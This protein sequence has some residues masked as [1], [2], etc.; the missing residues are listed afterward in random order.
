MLRTVLGL[1]AA[2]MFAVPAVD[3]YLGGVT[4]R[5][6]LFGAAALTTLIVTILRYGRNRRKV[7]SHD[8][9]G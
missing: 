1:I 2:A 7:R 5:T 8:V 4:V 3:S 6:V 9:H